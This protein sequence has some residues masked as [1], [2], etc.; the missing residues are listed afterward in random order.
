MF[1]P[2]TRAD[3]IGQNLAKYLWLEEMYSNKLQHFPHSTA[4]FDVAADKWDKMSPS[5]PP[6]GDEEKKQEYFD[7]IDSIC[8]GDTSTPEKC[9]SNFFLMTKFILS[10][11]NV[12]TNFF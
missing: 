12:L 2:E 11:I 9:V 6:P 7:F 1:L 5:M 3:R 10:E 4:H 8:Y